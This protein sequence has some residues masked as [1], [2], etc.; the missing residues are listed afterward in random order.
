[1]PVLIDQ[2]FNLA[3]IFVTDDLASLKQHFPFSCEDSASSMVT[4]ILQ[5]PL[6][7]SLNRANRVAEMHDAAWL[8]ATILEFNVMRLM[9]VSPSKPVRCQK[10]SALVDAHC[11]RQI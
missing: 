5:S 7:A 6:V 2:E 3:C 4:G 9:M 8:S 11:E 1:M 10:L